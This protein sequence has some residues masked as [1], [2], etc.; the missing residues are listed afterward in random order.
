[1]RSCCFIRVGNLG[2][3]DLNQV[4]GYYLLYEVLLSSMH[5]MYWSYRETSLDQTRMVNNR[6]VDE[7]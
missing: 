1:M 5:R 7:I 2:Y 6:T 4:L 3:L